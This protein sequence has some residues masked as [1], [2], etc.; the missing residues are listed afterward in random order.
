MN[1]IDLFW[2]PKI[3]SGWNVFYLHLLNGLITCTKYWRVSNK[4]VL[5]W[6]ANSNK[7]FSFS[8]KSYKK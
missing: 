6:K 8:G 5:V 4:L 7:K 3:T 1:E 2:K